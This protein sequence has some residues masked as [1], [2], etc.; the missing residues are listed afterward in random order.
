MAE[1]KQSSSQISECDDFE[2]KNVRSGGERFSKVR[3]LMVSQL[4]EAMAASLPLKVIE[5]QVVEIV[6]CEFAN[7]HRLTSKF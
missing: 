7:R 1:M 5:N 2:R 6:E 4:A 3:G